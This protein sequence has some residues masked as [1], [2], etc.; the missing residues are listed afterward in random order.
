MDIHVS[1]T[2]VD[3]NFQPNCD[4]TENSMKM[5]FLLRFCSVVLVVF[6]NFLSQL[7]EQGLSLGDLPFS[8]KTSSFTEPSQKAS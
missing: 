6:F 4:S 1:N 3:I 7:P 2:E 8:I 5:S